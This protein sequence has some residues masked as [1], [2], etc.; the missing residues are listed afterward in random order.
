MRS[1]LS[2]VL[3][4]C[5]I[6]FLL[7]ALAA[8]FAAA[9]AVARAAQPP[10]PWPA[11]LL[12]LFPLAAL[13]APLFQ[14]TRLGRY[15]AVAGSAVVA[16]GARVLM[17][18]PAPEVRLVAGSVVIAAGAAFLSCAV[19][20][21][22]RRSVAAG[23][24]AAVVLD[25]LL[26]LAGW[27]W[28]RVAEIRGGC[29]PSCW[30]RRRCALVAM[31]WL[32]MP[33]AQDGAEEA[34]AA[35]FTGA[36]GRGP[37]PP[38]W[39]SPGPDPVPRPARPGPRRSRC[40]RWLGVRYEVAAVLLAAAGA[41]AVLVLLAGN[42]PAGPL[43]Q[44]V[45]RAGADGSRRAWP[46]HGS[47]AAGQ[48]APPWPLATPRASCC[49]AGHWS[50]RPVAAAAVP[51]RWRWRLLAA[52]TALY[53]ASFSPAARIPGRDRCALDL[54]ARR[55]AA[56][57]LPAPAAPAP[58][59]PA[60]PRATPVRGHRGCHR[61]RLR[62]LTRIARSAVTAGRAGGRDLRVLVRDVAFGA[63]ADGRFDPAR[64]MQETAALGVDVVV[65]RNAGAAMPTAYGADLGPL[66]QPP[67]RPAPVRRR[68]AEPSRWRHRPVP[69]RGLSLPATHLPCATSAGPPPCFTWPFPR[70][71]T[72]STSTWPVTGAARPRA[73]ARARCAGHGG[74]HAA[75]LAGSPEALQVGSRLPSSRR[76]P[77]CRRAGTVRRCCWYAGWLQTTSSRPPHGVPPD[78]RSSAV[79]RLRTQW[80]AGDSPT[81]LTACWRQ[82]ARSR[83]VR[84][85]PLRLPA[86]T[87]PTKRASMA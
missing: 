34:F 69:R 41:A 54:P 46:P 58:R 75:M 62:R 36:P 9:P 44:L 42:G 19:G 76:L 72:P 27:G 66:P 87:S 64:V 4:A 84:D 7:E 73:G 8:V 31:R 52:L 3:T 78:H 67:P 13:F 60:A 18:L 23:V 68:W 26:R 21:L 35:G 57:V 14:L 80:R 55:R 10:G 49:S 28:S 29:C 77:A 79:L 12:L 56:G 40:T 37:A 47:S 61:A 83:V 82:G 50:R 25:Q 85:A 63:D 17:C 20:F 43:P 15:N 6:L 45:C 59:H 22:E 38:R 11:A 16:A 65:L 33:P 48:A 1:R 51:P 24:G 81:T 5:T 39:R 2:F 71:P 70:P 30:S 74:P 86:Q 53:A 32:A